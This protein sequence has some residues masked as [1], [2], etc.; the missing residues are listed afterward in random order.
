MAIQNFGEI[1]KFSRLAKDWW[2]E[3]GAMKPLHK[4]N[5]PRSL[6]IDTQI[7][8]TDKRLA[9]IGCGGGIFAEAMAE[10]GARVTAVD[11]SAELIEVARRH[12][13]EKKLTIDYQVGS[14]EQLLAKNGQKYDLVSCLEVLEHTDEPAQLVA[15]C[16]A[17][18]KKGGWAYFSTINRTAKA[19][20]LAILGA[21][22]LLGWLAKGTHSYHRFIRPAE[23][24][25]WLEVS[26]LTTRQVCGIRYDPLVNQFLLGDSVAVNYL[27]LAQKE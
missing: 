23:L 8:L 1:R 27:L 2:R 22:Y 9:D 5:Y 17:L 15:Q 18:L 14:A 10:R 4:I 26:G 19:Y 13:K 11:P 20:V 25:D 6:F 16:A 7:T 3:Q 24:N 21:E 12:S